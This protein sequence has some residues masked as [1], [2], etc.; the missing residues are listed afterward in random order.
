LH[1]MPLNP[2]PP[3]VVVLLTQI[4]RDPGRSCI[5]SGGNNRQTTQRLA[6]IIYGIPTSPPAD[7]RRS[8]C[9]PGSNRAKGTAGKTRSLTFRHP[10][11]IHDRPRSLFRPRWS[12]SR[13]EQVT[14]GRSDIRSAIQQATGSLSRRHRRYRHLFNTFLVFPRLHHHYQ[15]HHRTRSPRHTHLSLPPPCLAKPRKPKNPP[16]RRKR[17]PS[18]LLH[19]TRRFLR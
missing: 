11:A 1:L 4:D 6:G 17:K 7:R 16:L 10:G 19:P 3:L 5:N 18:P 8:T 12:N 15:Y 9:H 13:Y 2:R 14:L